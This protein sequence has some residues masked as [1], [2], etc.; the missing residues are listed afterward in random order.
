MAFVAIASNAFAGERDWASVKSWVYQL[1]NYQ[2]D[3]LDA[4]AATDFDLAVIDL[5][6]DGESGYFE[7]QEIEAL[8]ASGKIVLAYFEIGAIE[9]YRPEWDAVPQELKAGK[10]GGW[11]K[12]QYVKFWDE[13]WWPVVQGR[14]DQALKAGFDGAY[15]DMVTT[16]AEIPN[17]GLSSEERARRM[18][19]LIARISEYAKS[20]NPDFKIVPQNCPELYTWSYWTPQPN[21]QYIN[22]IDGLGL[23]SV[24]Y[25]A[26]NQPAD[27]D[28]CQ[29]NRDNAVA[30]RQAGKLVLGVD[31][32][33]KPTCI[34][35][36]YAK[37]RALGFVPYAS[38]E[39]LDTIKVP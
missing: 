29:E 17:T 33:T 34:A 12:E 5:T 32:A 28:W 36:G 22:A 38:V 31:Y 39:A 4:I 14:I 2:D 25:I 18:V 6:R 9:D 1:C 37:Q 8:K 16:Y 35:D 27:E 3:R 7:R 10:V 19:A 23:E 24:F 20:R 30:I 21:Q 13:R 11:P 15:L 26:H